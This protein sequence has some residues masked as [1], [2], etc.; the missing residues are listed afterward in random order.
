MRAVHPPRIGVTGL[1][2]LGRCRAG[3][4][5]TQQRSVACALTTPTASR[6]R[7]AARGASSRWPGWW[8]SRHSTTR[9]SDATRSSR[10]RAAVESRRRAVPA[11]R[12]AEAPGA[13]AVS[14]STPSAPI[15]CLDTSTATPAPTEREHESA[16]AIDAQRLDE[17]LGIAGVARAALDGAH[18]VP[19]GRRGRGLR[20]PH[21]EQSPD[22]LGIGPRRPPDVPPRR[23]LRWP[24]AVRGSAC[25]AAR[26]ASDAVPSGRAS[27]SRAA[28][29]GGRPSGRS[30][31]LL[32]G[33]RRAA[34]RVAPGLPRAPRRG[35]RAGRPRRDRC[36]PGGARQQRSGGAAR[37]HGPSRA[38]AARRR[39]GCA[40]GRPHSA[41]A[42]TRRRAGGAAPRLHRR[43]SSADSCTAASAA[44]PVQTSGRTV[45]SRPRRVAVVCAVCAARRSATAAARSVARVARRRRQRG[46]PGGRGAGARRSRGS[47]HRLTAAST[48]ASPDPRVPVTEPSADAAASSVSRSLRTARSSP[49][50]S[51]VTASAMASTSC[52]CTRRKRSIS[53]VRPGWPVPTADRAAADAAATASATARKRGSVTAD[54]GR[55]PSRPPRGPSRSAP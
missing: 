47:A 20:W 33:A 12:P 4:E 25:R 17:G 48:T 39:A 38:G 8:L 46:G 29:S 54:R 41:R 52:A 45:A 28:S 1:A 40:R 55:R 18:E 6:R 2:D 30:V 42:P 27:S 49:P 53:A 43:A 50:Q 22:A 5:A 23:Q 3:S 32:V 24:G 9:L 35:A 13:T 14:K 31:Q 36:P 11:S 10:S 26:L 21:R 44:D 37:R 16:Q 19:Q 7:R 15:A 51:A 34:A